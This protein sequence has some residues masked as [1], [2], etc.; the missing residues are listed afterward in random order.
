MFVQKTNN[1]P[2]IIFPSI[3]RSFE[4]FPQDGTKKEQ[5]KSEV[6]KCSSVT[7]KGHTI[8]WGSTRSRLSKFR[9]NRHMKVV[10]S[11]IR[12]G[13]LYSQEIYHVFISVRERV[14]LGVIVQPE[15][16]SQLK[17]PMTHSG[18]EPV[19]SPLAA[20]PGTTPPP[21]FQNRERRN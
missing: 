3:L 13:R 16:L 6:K 12:T 5:R 19:T 17:V 14:N 21:P 9:A 8:P 7:Q 11:A 1:T 20:P 10:T 2:R 18:I 15:E 4:F